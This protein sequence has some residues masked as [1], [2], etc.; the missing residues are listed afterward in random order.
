[1]AT[2]GGVRW[3]L[4]TLGT[5]PR[6]NLPS[7]ALSTDITTRLPSAPANTVTRLCLD[8]RMAAMRNVLSPEV[9]GAHYVCDCRGRG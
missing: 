8:A 7:A 5:S 1:M 3:R 9:S 2:E 6:M 4:L